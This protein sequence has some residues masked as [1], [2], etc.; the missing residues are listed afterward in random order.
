MHACSA[1]GL[2]FTLHLVRNGHHTVLVTGGEPLVQIAVG[3]LLAALLADDYRVLLETSGTTLPSNSLALGEVPAGVYRIVD[4]KPPA[5]GIAADLIDW[6]GIGRLGP[7]DE[8]KIVCANRTD[9]EWAR[10]LVRSGAKMPS[11]VRVALSP[12]QDTLPARQLAEW[13][14]ADG[15]EVCFQIQLH[16]V[17]WPDVERGV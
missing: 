15:L 17:L 13:I 11:A 1:D 12:V 9:Y 2:S 3:D 14:L 6:E 5:S 16:K 8:L 7:G 4:I 10:E